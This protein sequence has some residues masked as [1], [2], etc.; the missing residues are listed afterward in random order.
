M[1]HFVI[2]PTTT[3]DSSSLDKAIENQFGKKCYRLPRGEWLVSFAGTSRQLSDELGVSEGEVGVAA[4]VFNYSGYF[5]RA[6][7][8][9]WEW[10]AVNEGA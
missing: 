6:N 10:I 2:I 9:I 7:K 3:N 1:A 5:G 8:D 4:A